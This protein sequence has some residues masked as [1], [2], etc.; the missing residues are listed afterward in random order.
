MN[1]Q[2]QIAAAKAA[3]AKS[4][5]TDPRADSSL[6]FDPVNSWDDAY[7]AAKRLARKAIVASDGYSTKNLGQ[8]AD[9]INSTL[10]HGEFGSDMPTGCQIALQRL[11]QSIRRILPALRYADT[12]CDTNEEA[13]ASTE[14]DFT[15][16]DL[17][18][19]A[20]GWT[21]L[22]ELKGATGS[23][24]APPANADNPV[25]PSQPFVRHNPKDWAKEEEIEFYFLACVSWLASHGK[26]GD[27]I[28]L[29]DAMIRHKGPLQ[30]QWT[31][32]IPGFCEVAQ[33]K[34]LPGF[35]SL[36]GRY[37][38]AVA[39]AGVAGMYYYIMEGAMAAQ[40][41]QNGKLNFSVDSGRRVIEAFPPGHKIGNPPVWSTLPADLVVPPETI[42]QQIKDVFTA[43]MAFITYF[44]SALYSLATF[45]QD[46]DS[47]KDA[48]GMATNASK[49]VS[50]FQAATAGVEQVYQTSKSNADA[51]NGTTALVFAEG[52]ATVMADILT[53]VEAE[54]EHN[55]T[56]GEKA[57]EQADNTLSAASGIPWADRLFNHSQ[58]E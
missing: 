58:W 44:A 23:D 14:Y 16:Y 27:A 39:R 45:G 53:Q 3:A 52:Q 19:L 13:S 38:Y 42:A 24:G 56:V 15:D 36:N 51:M 10:R 54:S 48:I 49:L 21:T 18:S 37:R 5:S 57:A 12:P 25:G 40:F 17:Y 55:K 26:T 2:A 46:V 31:V 34:R 28:A 41:K 29:M 33:S 7:N 32:R 6:I 43:A 1:A 8:D 30:S 9:N 50:R 47:V 35:A 22:D 20:N 11:D 4:N